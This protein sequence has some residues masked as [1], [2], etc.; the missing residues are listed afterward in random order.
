MALPERRYKWSG[1][2]I[3]ALGDLSLSHVQTM[4]C[5]QT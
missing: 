1:E 5:V 3:A 2:E 4:V